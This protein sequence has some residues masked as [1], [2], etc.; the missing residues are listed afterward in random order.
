MRLDQSNRK[1][2]DGTS[3]FCAQT[4]CSARGLIVIF[5]WQLRDDLRVLPP[6]AAPRLGT[7]EKAG[8]KLWI[9]FRVAGNEHDEHTSIKHETTHRFTFPSHVT[10]SHFLFFSLSPISSSL[11]VVSFFLRPF[12]TSKKTCLS[13]FISFFFLVFCSSFLL[14]PLPLTRIITQIRSRIRALVPAVTLCFSYRSSISLLSL[15]SV[16]APVFFLFLA[17]FL[18][19]LRPRSLA[20]LLV[21][22]FRLSFAASPSYASLITVCALTAA[23]HQDD[24]HDEHDHDEDQSESERG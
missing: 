8:S 11:S 17:F 14:L 5:T 24:E 19:R 1:G 9:R 15:P 3:V 20:C 23:E 4:Q 7:K 10:S 16:I 13:F 22:T 21:T 2:R 18:R 6:P 12:W